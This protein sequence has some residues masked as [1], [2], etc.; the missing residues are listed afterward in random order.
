MLHILCPGKRRLPSKITHLLSRATFKE[1]SGLGS[2]SRKL[3]SGGVKNAIEYR[4]VFIFDSSWPL[5]KWTSA[6]TSAPKYNAKNSNQNLKH[7]KGEHVISKYAT[8]SFENTSFHF[9]DNNEYFLNMTAAHSFS[10]STVSHAAESSGSCSVDC[11]NVLIWPDALYVKNARL[12]D[13]PAITKLVASQSSRITVEQAK[14]TFSKNDGGVEVTEATGVLALVA[15]SGE[16]FPVAAHHLESL[17]AATANNGGDDGGD[18]KKSHFFMTADVRGHRNASNVMLFN[19]GTG[20]E[21]CFESYDSTRAAE[22]L[23]S[24]L[25]SV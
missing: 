13:I 24:H 16:A 25:N 8:Y 2:T 9:N 1:V 19:C 20:E 5:E 12:A 10:P 11:H 3:S 21:D 4:D 18:G 22:A 23:C 15:C 17:R 6:F 14:H 7:P